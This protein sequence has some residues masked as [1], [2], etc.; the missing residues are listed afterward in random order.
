MVFGYFNFNFIIIMVEHFSDA[1][2]LNIKIIR[3]LKKQLIFPSQLLKTC[4]KEVR[5]N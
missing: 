2:L 5:S 4:E 3:K 1:L